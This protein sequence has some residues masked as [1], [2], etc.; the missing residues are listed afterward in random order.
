MKSIAFVY[1]LMFASLASAQNSTAFSDCI[2]NETSQ[3]GT[4]LLVN[5]CNIRVYVKF[6]DGGSCKTGCAA[7]INANGKYAIPNVKGSI[8]WAVCPYPKM[9]R[10]DRNGGRSTWVDGNYSCL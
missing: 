3:Y 6:Y 10:V 9:P 1:I 5:S 8:R 7:N 2:E 4:S